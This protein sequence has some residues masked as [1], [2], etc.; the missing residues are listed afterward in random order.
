MP[1]FSIAFFGDVVGQPGVRAFSS[2]CCDIRQNGR[3]DLIIV[4]GE[5]SRNNGSGITPETYK[6]LRRAGA[7]AITLGDHC[8]KDKRIADLLDDPHKPVARPANL[9]ASAR[10]KKW[11][12]VAPPLSPSVEPAALGGGSAAWMKPWAEGR[13]PP[14]YVVTVLGR[15]FMPIPSDDPFAAVDREAAAIAAEAPDA[16]IVVEIHAEATSEKQAMAW[17]CLRRW[18]QRVVAVVGT[19]THVQT[20]DARLLEGTIAAISDLGMCG[21]HRGVIGRKVAAVLE[22]MTTQN[23]AAYDVADEELAATGVI[24]RVDSETRRAIAA[25]PVVCKL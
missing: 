3:A 11:S 18:P 15:L 20:A 5:N 23:H 21:G 16:L 2:A 25:D 13:L 12:R 19:H 24:I 6:D 10:G 9:S 17:H 8:F 14:V 22:V 1:A 4:N 7:D